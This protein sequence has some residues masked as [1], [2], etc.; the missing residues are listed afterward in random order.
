MEYRRLGRSDLCLSVIS[1]GNWLTHGD[2]VDDAT[3]VACVSKAL[4]AGITVFD[5]ADMY[6]DG[7]AEELLG[8]ALTGVRR[9]SVVVCS[10]VGLPT[11]TALR[12]G[13]CRGSG[14]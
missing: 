12:T 14:S 10:K 11:S 7:R 5:T 4:E 9:E 6:A 8:F 1:Y 3:A 2:G 13:D